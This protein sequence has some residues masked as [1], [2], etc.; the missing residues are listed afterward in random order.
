MELEHLPISPGEILADAT[1][2]MSVY[3]SDKK[4]ELLCDIDPNLPQLIYGDPGRLRQIAVNLVGNAIKFTD[5]GEVRLQAYMDGVAAAETSVLHLAVHDT[6]PG[7]PADRHKAIFESFQQNDSS[8]TRR[9]GGTGLGLTITAELVALM[10]GRIWV[11]SE[12]GKGS[13]FHVT[14]ACNAAGEKPEVSQTLTDF[15]VYLV[16]QTQ[17]AI[18]SYCVG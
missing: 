16:S 5:E 18:A 17:N 1:K 12:V 7:I 9:Y 6:G 13:T 10:G 11:E 3:A 2:L 14:I 4:V 15:K 8:T